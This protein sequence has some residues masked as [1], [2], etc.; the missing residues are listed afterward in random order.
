[1]LETAEIA[2]ETALPTTLVALRAAEEAPLAAEDAAEDAPLTAEEA[3]LE[4]EVAALLAMLETIEAVEAAVLIAPAAAVVEL[5][6]TFPATAL[7]KFWSSRLPR[8]L[9]RVMPSAWLDK[10][11][12]VNRTT[13]DEFPII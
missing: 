5:E 3:M 11:A 9:N 7:T 12:L 13:I 8:V 2:A 1:V 6:V 4:A 10:Q